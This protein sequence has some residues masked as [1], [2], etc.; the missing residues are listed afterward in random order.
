MSIVSKNIL[1]SVFV[2][3]IIFNFYLYAQEKFDPGKLN[4]EA[5][6]ETEQ[7][8]QLAG[9]WDAQQTIRNRDGSW[10]DKTTKAEWRWYYILDGQAIQDDWFS[11]D[12]ANNLQWVGTNIRIYNPDE[13]QWYMAWI[14]KT[15]R[16]LA[17]FI[18]TYEDGIMTMD[19]T[20]AKGRHI[21]N[22]FS[23]LSKESFDWVQQWTFDEGKTWV[24]V[25]KIHCTKK[26]K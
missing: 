9:I 14:D 12:S 6:Q 22:I 21:K 5:P 13:K 25:T 4:P 19:G 2:L 26:N 24:E 17:T 20:N 1:N 7:F 10:S 3:L 11:A 16:K 8:G 15:N 18:S 23:N